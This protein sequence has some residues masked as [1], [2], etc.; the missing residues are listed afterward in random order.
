MSGMVFVTLLR[1]NLSGLI[2]QDLVSC[3]FYVVVLPLGPDLW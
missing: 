1:F 2:C 3:Y